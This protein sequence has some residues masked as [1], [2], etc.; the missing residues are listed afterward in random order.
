MPSL[1]IIPLTGDAL[2]TYYAQ[3]AEEDHQS[4]ADPTNCQDGFPR[5]CSDTMH[6]E[7]GMYHYTHDHDHCIQE[8]ILD[9]IGT[10]SGIP[11]HASEHK[12][13]D[14]RNDIHIHICCYKDKDRHENEDKEKCHLSDGRLEEVPLLDKYANTGT[15]ESH[16]YLASS[17]RDSWKRQNQGLYEEH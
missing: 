13:C 12:D 4:Y 17:S 6:H 11:T 2:E 3:K 15:P 8:P 1:R 9:V 5:D 7:S 10:S 16:E 14:G